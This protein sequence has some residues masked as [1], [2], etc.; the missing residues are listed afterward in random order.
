[1]TK[2]S[3]IQIC[4]AAGL[5]LNCVK[6]I[7]VRTDGNYRISRSISRVFETQNSSQK[8]D[9]DLYPGHKKYCPG[10]DYFFYFHMFTIFVLSGS[11]AKLSSSAISG[12]TKIYL[13]LINK[14]KFERVCLYKTCQNPVTTANHVRKTFIL[15][16]QSK[17]PSLTMY[18]SCFLKKTSADMSRLESN[19]NVSLI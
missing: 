6:Q 8:I 9:L 7:E 16:I 4:L 11:V 10:V 2:F 3:N 15:V 17:N 1:M 5:Y 18:I 12:K 13:F 14:I 19:S